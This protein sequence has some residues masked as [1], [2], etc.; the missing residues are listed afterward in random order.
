MAGIVFLWI[1]FPVIIANLA[2]FPK[3][4]T[5]YKI[6]DSPMSLSSIFQII[7]ID[8]HGPVKSLGRKLVISLLIL[9]T[10]LPQV[11]SNSF[12]S[13]FLVC[14]LCLLWALLIL[15]FD[16]FDMNQ[17]DT[18]IEINGHRLAS[19]LL[20]VR[21]FA[22]PFNL[23]LWRNVATRTPFFRRHFKLSLNCN[24]TDEQSTTKSRITERTRLLSQPEVKSQ[25]QTGNGGSQVIR[26]IDVFK[27]CLSVV[28]LSILYLLIALPFTCAYIFKLLLD[29]YLGV[30]IVPR[31]LENNQSRPNKYKLVAK[32]IVA[33]FIMLLT[34]TSFIKC[35]ILSF[36]FIAGLYLNVGHYSAYF[37]SLSLVLVY[38]WRNWRSS[39]ETKYL[40]LKTNIYK[41]CKENCNPVL[42]TRPEIHSSEIRPRRRF[43]IELD[44][45]NV[46]VIPKPLYDI[47]REALLPYDEILLPFF[48]KIFLVALFAYFLFLFQSLSQT[49]GESSNTKILTTIVAT[50]IPFLFDL[51][52]TQNSDAHKTANDLALK[53]KLERTL[54][55]CGVNNVT[56]EILVEFVGDPPTDPMDLWTSD[57]S[58]MA[59]VLLGRGGQGVRKATGTV[60][61]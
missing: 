7:F 38:S 59:F 14:L 61:S 17:E 33:L 9:L 27:Y 51:I 34:L 28:I 35:L 32:V 6:L 45:N 54:K 49:S 58:F 46:P 19:Y 24:S 26:R 53:S 55:V 5:T 18:K 16:V 8:G 56:G 13:V 57:F 48:A 60:T 50:L 10:A 23:K 15:L 31:G 47:V 11:D 39:V 21:L 30:L 42:E 25:H 4:R 1:L 44:K 37:V 12:S 43:Q 29:K 2:S 52:W 20:N 36:Y 41:F 3:E 22:L 40:E